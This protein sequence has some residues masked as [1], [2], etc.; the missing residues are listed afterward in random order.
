MADVEAIRRG[1]AALLR[2]VYPVGAGHV[3][4]YFK[5]APAP[6]TLQIIGVE[7]MVPLDMTDGA[8]WTWL[9]EGYF[10]TITDRGAQTKLDEILATDQVWEAVESDNAR[11]G[12]LFSRLQ[13]DGTVTTDEDDPAADHVAF[14]EYRGSS[15]IERGGADALVGTWAVRVLT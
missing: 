11:D 7:R 1:L 5:D 2:T 13:D 10:G 3:G 14:L 15:R 8:D 4:A 6:P 12:A 9:I